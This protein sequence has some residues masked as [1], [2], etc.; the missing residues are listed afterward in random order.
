M[1][2]HTSPASHDAQRG[3]TLIEVLIVVALIGVIAS[4]AIPSLMTARASANEASAIGST[5]TAA[6]GQSAFA[7]TCGAGFY[8]VDNTHLVTAGFAGADFA[9]PVKHGFA[10][11]LTVGDLGVFGELDCN[12]DNTVTDYYFSATP[13]SPRQ[14]RRA[15]ATDENSS[16]WVDMAG[17]APV[18][19]FVEAGTVVPLR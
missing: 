3:F 18:E 17:V 5:R 15:F 16:I 9:L 2:R 7:A 14:G 11:T 12:G 13:T 10:M 8:A 6:S 19:P 1:S 4:I